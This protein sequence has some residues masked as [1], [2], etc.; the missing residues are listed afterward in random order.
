MSEFHVGQVVRYKGFRH[1]EVGAEYTVR[2]VKSNTLGVAGG[3]WD[4]TQRFEPI[5]P[6][7][8]REGDTVRCVKACYHDD[9][10]VGE[11][12]T[13]F[14][15]S[16][17]NLMFHEPML[18]I[19]FN[20]RVMGKSA[21]ERFILIKRAETKERGMKTY[22]VSVGFGVNRQ[23]IYL[24]PEEAVAFINEA[25]RLQNEMKES[26]EYTYNNT[27]RQFSATYLNRLTFRLKPKTS[28]TPFK[29]GPEK[30]EV[31]AD[32]DEV[33]IGCKSFNLTKFRSMLKALTTA[34]NFCNSVENDDGEFMA[35][36]SGICH[37]GEDI[38][39]DDAERI[40]KALEE[41]DA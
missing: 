38:S 5:P 4:L 10:E 29:V 23:E 13:I 26:L 3:D 11:E 14:T 33:S 37:E 31:R 24:Q 39:W 15:G 21:G 8:W 1:L 22:K 2:S 27:T 35:C 34:A 17:L 30:W 40:L 25:G 16:S 41:Y 18:Y 32:G 6:S 28:F 12:F 36:R 9:S 7:E 19:N 20:Q